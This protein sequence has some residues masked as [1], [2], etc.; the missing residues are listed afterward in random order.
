MTR[1]QILKGKLPKKIDWAPDDA[2]FDKLVS[3][4]GQDLKI[5]FIDTEKSW[6]PPIHWVKEIDAARGRFFR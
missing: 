4:K 2:F 3:E 5:R 1:F 6:R